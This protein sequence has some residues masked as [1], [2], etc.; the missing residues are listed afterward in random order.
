MLPVFWPGAFQLDT[1]HTGRWA[2]G[3]GVIGI[4]RVVHVGCIEHDK[5]VGR[6][7]HVKRVEYKY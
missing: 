7:G 4:K 5:R 2:L 3:F 6:V 1:V